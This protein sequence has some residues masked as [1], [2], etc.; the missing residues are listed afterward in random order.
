M[1]PEEVGKGVGNAIKDCKEV[2]FEGPY[3]TFSDVSVVDI[4]RDELEGTVPVFNDGADIFGTGFV[5]EDLE[6]HAVSFSLEA[7]HDGI[8]GCETMAIGTRLERPDNDGVGIYVVGKHDVLVAAAGADGE[9]THV[10]SVELSNRIYLD[11][12]FLGLDSVEWTGN[13]RKRIYGDWL[14]WNLPLCGL[15]T[16]AG[17]REVSFE[18][19]F[20]DGEVFGGIVE[21]EFMSGIKVAS[22]DGCKPRGLDSKACCSMEVSD[23]GSNAGQVMGIQGG[24]RGAPLRWDRLMYLRKKRETPK[25][26]AGEF[27]PTAKDEH[28]VLG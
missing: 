27:A 12:D 18:V 25:F 17:F 14:Q 28:V 24:G 2:G 4:R 20:R 19:L 22:M 7:I 16:L 21:G 9:P 3:G 10:I 26:G 23:K 8:V 6:V 15:E 13:V 5:V 11:M 1:F